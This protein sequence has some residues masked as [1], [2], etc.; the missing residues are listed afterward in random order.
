[1]LEGK[2]LESLVVNFGSPSGEPI[3][4]PKQVPPSPDEE[5]E[6]DEDWKEGPVVGVVE[7]PPKDLPN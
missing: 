5:P 1:M 4:L 6:K 7:E 3:P 2:E